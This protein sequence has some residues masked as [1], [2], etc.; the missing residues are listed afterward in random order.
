MD[1]VA[2]EVENGDEIEDPAGAEL[3]EQNDGPAGNE[4]KGKYTAVKQ[5]RFSDNISTPVLTRDGKE[6]DEKEVT[7]RTEVA[8]KNKKTYREALLG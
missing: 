6:A 8:T 1:D 2:S 5:V 7:G 3:S 4:N